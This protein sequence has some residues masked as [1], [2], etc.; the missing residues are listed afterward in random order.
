MQSADHHAIKIL[1][2]P[3]RRKR[4]HKIPEATIFMQTPKQQ[5]R[6]H[7]L[8]KFIKMLSDQQL[9]TGLSI[10]IAA[11]SSRCVISQT[12]WHIVTSLAY[13]SATTHSLSLDVLRNHLAQHTWVRYF[14]IT[15]T[16]FFLI[17]FTFAFLV[18]HLESYD[19]SGNNKD[20][21][22]KGWI[23]QC[24]LQEWMLHPG[25]LDSMDMII[26]VFPVLTILWGKHISAMTRLAGPG[27]D[28]HRHATATMMDRMSI[29]LCS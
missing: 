25:L 21:S 19:H 26:V 27:V 11:F 10:L 6:S 24:A 18:D 8:V 2:S 29:Y 17:L 28:S 12:E 7:I 20:E 9:I 15:F 4:H 14:R 22:I 1:K 16:L 5:S 23:V 3:F 13:F